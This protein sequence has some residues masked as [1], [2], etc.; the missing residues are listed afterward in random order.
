[1]ESFSLESLKNNH[2]LHASLAGV[3]TSIAL[4]NNPNNKLIGLSVATGAYYWMYYYGHTLPGSKGTIFDNT[5]EEQ[6]VH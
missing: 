6:I 2:L 3:I 5:V 4:R 1:M